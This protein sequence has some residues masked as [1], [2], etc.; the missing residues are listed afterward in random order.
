MSEIK[1]DWRDYGVRI[2]RS[3][4]LHLNTLQT[5]G[6]SR[7]V[8]ITHAIIAASRAPLSVRWTQLTSI[9]YAASHH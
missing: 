9:R 2:T 1:V 5:P 6:M 3:D 7:A 4:Q 8:A